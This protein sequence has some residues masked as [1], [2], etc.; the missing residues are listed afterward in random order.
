VPVPDRPAAILRLEPHML[1][2]LITAYQDAIGELRPLLIDL[3][4]IGRIPRAWTEDPVTEQIAARFNEHAVDGAHSAY[5]ALRL[6]ERELQNILDALRR[7]EA[8]YRS[9]EDTAAALMRRQ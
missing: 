4:R 2:S 6:Y 8:D 1:P 7:M 9:T 3:S 5:A